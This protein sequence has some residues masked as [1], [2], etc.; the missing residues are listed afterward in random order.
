M[1][2]VAPR[3]EEGELIKDIEGFEGLYAITSH[4]RVWSYPKPMKR[5]GKWLSVRRDGFYPQVVLVKDGV[6]NPRMVHRLVAEHFIPNPH[7]KPQVNHKDGDKTNNRMDNLEWVTP[8]ENGQHAYR[9]ELS[10]PSVNQRRSAMKLTDEQ[11]RE[12]VE[13]YKAGSITTR[14]LAKEYGC[15][16]ALVSM[17]INGK[18][19]IEHPELSKE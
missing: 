6:K 18:R 4:G 16:C 15:S 10:K 9:T 3:L 2:T 11:R 17:L 13:R 7:N 12:I 8:S 5:G 1:I 19:R 14:Q